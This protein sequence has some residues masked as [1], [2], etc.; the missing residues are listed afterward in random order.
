MLQ[1]LL[2]HQSGHTLWVQHMVDAATDGSP[3]WISLAVLY[4]HLIGRINATRL[5]GSDLLRDLHA[6][7]TVEATWVACDCVPSEPTGVGLCKAYG[8]RCLLYAL[9][10]GVFRKTV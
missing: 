6:T 3:I 1:G 2:A 8:R 10:D 4:A 9:F 5:G 7:Q